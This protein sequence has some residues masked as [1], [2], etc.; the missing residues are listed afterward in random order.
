MPR[1]DRTGPGGMGPMTGRAAGYCAGNTAPGFASAA[2][3]R[4]YGGGGYGGGR[5]RGRA[6]RN[7]FHA[8]GLPGWQRAAWGWPAFGAAPS[9][10]FTPPT[11]VPDQELDAL[12]Q[13]A[14]ML[15]S[16]LDGIRD[17][18]AELESQAKKA[19]AAGSDA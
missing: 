10:P 11:I 8:T 14:E 1:G 3:G 17:R 2:G 19:A 6:R 15:S 16:T 4:G 13:Q 5:G 9:V 7:W 18:I 12:R